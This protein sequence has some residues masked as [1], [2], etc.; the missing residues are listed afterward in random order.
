MRTVSPTS[1]PNY[2]I[3]NRSS[4]PGDFSMTVLVAQNYTVLREELH[5]DIP[6]T[7]VDVG[8][9][10]LYVLGGLLLEGDFDFT[11]MLPIFESK[12][13]ADEFA[14]RFNEEL[15]I[16]FNTATIS[17]IFGV[18]ERYTRAD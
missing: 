14:R 16:S 1:T 18:Y 13:E 10:L 11:S 4:R 6:F 17:A 8:G 9:E 2:V 15:G 5:Q 3:L 7:I 12:E